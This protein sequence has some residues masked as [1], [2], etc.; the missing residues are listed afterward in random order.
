[1][2]INAKDQ[3]HPSLQVETEVDRVENLL[4]PVGEAV[5]RNRRGQGRERDH[6]TEKY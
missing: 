2:G 3:V 6:D 5:A 4:P 1:L